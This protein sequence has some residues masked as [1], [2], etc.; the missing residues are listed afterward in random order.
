MFIFVEGYDYFKF[1]L[2]PDIQQIWIEINEELSFLGAV[3]LMALHSKPIEPRAI[4]FSNFFT[5]GCKK[6][7][8]A[9]RRGLERIALGDNAIE[10][11]NGSNTP[12]TR[13]LLTAQGP[14]IQRQIGMI[15][16]ITF[17]KQ[18]FGIGNF[19]QGNTLIV[20][21]A[22]GPDSFGFN[23]PFVGSGSGIWLLRQMEAIEIDE[24]LLY[25]INAKN[26]KGK[27]AEQDF[28]EFLRPKRI[29]TLGMQAKRWASNLE[30]DFRVVNLYHP[31]YWRRFQSALKYP[32]LDFLK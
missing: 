2:G 5:K 23:T 4:I 27:E 30:K 10:I 17:D 11:V 6:L 7:L 25:W 13:Y 19:S 18:S 12:K 16:A 22:P 20:G 21:E 14:N 29:I 9:Q 15:R 24:T 28:L 32:L 1:D 8:L 3:H 26:H 31:A